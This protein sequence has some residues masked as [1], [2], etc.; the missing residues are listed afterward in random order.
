MVNAAFV[1]E[2]LGGGNPLGRRFRY[3]EGYRSGGVMRTPAGTTLGRW[4]EVVGVVSDLP[5]NAM[6][7]RE[8]TVRIYHPLKLEELS[9]VNLALR[10]RVPPATF[11]VRLQEIGTA[12]DPALQFREVRTLDSAVRLFQGGMRLGALAL[13]LMTLSVLLLSAAGTYAL[14]S[15]T[16]TQRRREIGIRAA[17]G[18]NPRHIVGNVFRRAAGQLAMG[19]VTGAG[20]AAVIDGAVG[21]DLLGGEAAVVLPLIALLIAVVGLLAAVGPAMRGLRIQTSETLRAEG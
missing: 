14:M 2:T 15:F 17:L 4:Y 21:G 1:R 3:V 7:P 11:A 20:A 10:T 8:T 19:L 6:E 13:G 18:A 12:L 16:V 5:P 9:P